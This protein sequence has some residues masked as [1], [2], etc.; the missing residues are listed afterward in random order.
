[1]AA[2]ARQEHDLKAKYAKLKIDPSLPALERLRAYVMS[3]GTRS[4][5]QLSTYVS[6]LVSSFLVNAPLHSQHFSTTH[7]WCKIFNAR[8]GWYWVCEMNA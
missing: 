6:L 3:K 7:I 5:K 2:T 4:L 1:M 8:Q